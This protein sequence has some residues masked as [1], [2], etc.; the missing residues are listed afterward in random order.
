MPS[1]EAKFDLQIFSFYL[2]QVSTVIKGGGVIINL[3]DYGRFASIAGLLFRHWLQ[4]KFRNATKTRWI[5][6]QQW[7][8]LLNGQRHE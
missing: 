4:E 8:D 7:D 1:S 6:C 3:T 2:S 5:M